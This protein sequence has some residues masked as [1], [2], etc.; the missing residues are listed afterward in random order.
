MTKMCARVQLVCRIDPTLNAQVRAQAARAGQT[1]TT[2]IE[3]ALAPAL[4][5]KPAEP[6]ERSREDGRP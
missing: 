1:L 3:R 4:A 2:W 6:H 5:G